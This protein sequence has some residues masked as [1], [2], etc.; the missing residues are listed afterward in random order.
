MRSITKML[1]LAPALFLA[2][3]SKDKAPDPALTN[4]LTLAAQARQSAII[5]SVTAVE[6]LKAAD[7][8]AAAKAATPVVHHTATTTTHHT[9]ASSGGSVAAAEPQT[10]TEKNTKRDA[11]IGGAAGAILGAT[12]S[13]DKVKG[14]LIGGAAGAILGGVIGNNVDIHKKKVP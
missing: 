7:Q 13:H 8:V 10:V 5:D 3:C 9:T 12:T 1:F 6:R 4:D 2:A 14:G 11:A